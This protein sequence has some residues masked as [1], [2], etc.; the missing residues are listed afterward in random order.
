VPE[1]RTSDIVAEARSELRRLAAGVRLPPDVQADD[2]K[3]RDWLFTVL[4]LVTVGV[5]LAIM[6]GVGW[7]KSQGTLWVY[8]VAMVLALANLGARWWLDVPLAITSN[9]FVA[10][11]YIT[12]TAVTLG[13]GG[14]GLAAPF[15]RQHEPRDPHADERGDGQPRP[16]ARWA[17]STPNSSGRRG[18]APLGAGVAVR[19]RRHRRHRAGRV[20]RAVDR[21][22]ALRRLGTWSKRSSTCFGS[23]AKRR[24]SS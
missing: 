12:L 2:Q 6:I 23:R 5:N 21:R 14:V 9:I 17:S 13:T 3:R 20:G 1:P 8:T 18:R 11:V 7:E 4:T 24:P 15:A 19:A 22:P 10:M 16:A